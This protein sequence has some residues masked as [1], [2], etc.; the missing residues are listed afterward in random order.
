MWMKL[1]V[2]YI[3]NSIIL[4]SN[5]ATLINRF[6]EEACN[7]EVF[8]K[9]IKGSF[10]SRYYPSNQSS[11]MEPDTEMLYHH[12]SKDLYEIHKSHHFAGVGSK[13]IL[14]LEQ[15]TSPLAIV[16]SHIC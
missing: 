3:F 8:K 2:L 1:H 9:L 7:L 16:L 4:P 14:L 13:Y 11:H 6:Q 5:G 10:Q 12:L 15:Q